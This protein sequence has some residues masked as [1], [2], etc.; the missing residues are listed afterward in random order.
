MDTR[1]ESKNVMNI[2]TITISNKLRSHS[3]L[4]VTIGPHLSPM[5][6]SP[7][8]QSPNARSVDQPTPT[9]QG[10]TTQSSRHP[11]RPPKQS[12]V[13]RV[14]CGNGCYGMPLGVYS[15]DNSSG[16]VG[17]RWQMLAKSTSLF[18]PSSNRSVHGTDP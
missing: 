15:V 7:Y 8:T 5:E 6:S 16:S 13:A 10:L 11:D 1:D 17:I 3:A 9:S 12:S 2:V 18:P 14:L 4:S